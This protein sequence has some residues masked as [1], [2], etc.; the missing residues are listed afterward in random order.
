MQTFRRQCARARVPADLL[1]AG[2]LLQR[3]RCLAVPG[4]VQAALGDGCGRV[5]RAV[6]VGAG[7]TGL[8]RDRSSHD[9]QLPGAGGRGDF[10]NQDPVQS[11][12]SHQT[13]RL[14]F[15]ERLARRA[16]PAAKSLRLPAGSRH[17]CLWP[18]SRV[19][20]DDDDART[21]D[22][23]HLRSAG[24]HLLVLAV[25]LHCWV[26]VRLSGGAVSG[27]GLCS[28]WSAAPRCV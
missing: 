16:E 3:Q 27:V 12:S 5:F 24:R 26:A 4:E 15:V 19:A 23:S 6:S 25:R 14:L 2:F 7:D 28:F 17:Q 21:V 10:G 13:R 1:T 22:L 9:T 11:Q 8:A 20:E 18:N